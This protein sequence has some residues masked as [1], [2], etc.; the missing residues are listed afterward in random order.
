MAVDMWVIIR[1]LERRNFSFYDG[2]MADIDM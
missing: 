2:M 1:G